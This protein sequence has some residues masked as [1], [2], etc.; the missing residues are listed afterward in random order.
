MEGFKSASKGTKD[1]KLKLKLT[2]GISVFEFTINIIRH[3]IEL[4]SSE[5]VNDKNY[6]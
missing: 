5:V 4:L 1:E 6:K 3:K 2:G